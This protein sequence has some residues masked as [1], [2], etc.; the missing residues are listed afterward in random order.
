LH[1]A[2]AQIIHHPAGRSRPLLFHHRIFHRI[3]INQNTM[4]K[5]RIIKNT[6]S[7]KRYL[8]HVGHAHQWTPDKSF[9]MEYTKIEVA[10][11]LAEKYHGELEAV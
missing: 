3:T 7:G 2:H 9:A 8:S 1:E 11:A 4:N 10:Q 5:F 6:D